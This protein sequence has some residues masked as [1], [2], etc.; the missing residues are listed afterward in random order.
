MIPVGILTGAATS[1]FTFLLDQYPGSLI[2][3]S[4]RKL[5]S[6][7]TG[8]CIQVRRS[9]DNATQNIGFVNNVLDVS[10]LTT[11][12][13]S[14]S[15][16]ISIWYDQSTNGLNFIQNTLANQ[17]AII[18]SGVLQTVNGK[19]AVNLNNNNTN[20]IVNFPLPVGTKITNTFDVCKTS[21]TNFILYHGGSGS[22]TFIGCA[23]QSS[24]NTFVNG[25]LDTVSQIYKNNVLQTLPTTRGQ[26]YTLIATNTQIILSYVMTLFNWSNLNFS[27]YTSF[28]FVGLKQEFIMYEQQTPNISGINNNI[29]SF[30][31]IF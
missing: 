23:T 13:G 8:N 2:A 30:Y 4:L 6:A 17:P 24:T 12:I 3:V 15:G 19:P 5:R 1:S 14:N 27:G 18:I 16:F 25:N 9:S 29:N 10:T 20:L 7:Y 31:T 26:A 28:E 11:F 21:D 22:G